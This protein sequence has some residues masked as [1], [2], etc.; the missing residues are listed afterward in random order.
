M[1][2]LHSFVFPPITARATTDEAP[3]GAYDVGPLGLWT[4]SVVGDQLAIELSDGGGKQLVIAQ[5]D[6]LRVQSVGGTVTFV[7]DA[8]GVVTHFLL[9]IVEG[10]F[11]AVRK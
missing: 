11:T 4:V 3:A 9:T 8:K 10:D 2:A 6:G 5:T 1:A 7:R